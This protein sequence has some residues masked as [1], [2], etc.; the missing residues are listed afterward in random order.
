MMKKRKLLRNT[1]VFP[2]YNEIVD[3]LIEWG[4]L[5]HNSELCAFEIVSVINPS[6]DEMI[7]EDV[8]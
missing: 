7:N 2:A 6:H 1:P 3:I 5:R 8:D 4:M